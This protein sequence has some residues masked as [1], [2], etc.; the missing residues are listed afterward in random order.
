MLEE[1]IADLRYGSV[2]VNVWNAAAFLLVQASWGAYPGHTPDDIQ[3]GSGVVGNAFMFEKP[4]KT[5]VRGSFYP[6]PRTW[7]HG[8]PAFLPKPPWFVTNKT[9]HITTKG[10]AKITLD[11][12]FRYL[13]AILLSALRG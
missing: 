2:G 6:L 1:A 11:P 8:D 9:A 4:E 13:P 12:H 5:V 10:V 7:L 3:S